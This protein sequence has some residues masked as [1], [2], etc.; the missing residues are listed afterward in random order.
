MPSVVVKLVLLSFG[1]MTV[2]PARL[3]NGALIETISKNPRLTPKG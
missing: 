3:N 1:A 2:S